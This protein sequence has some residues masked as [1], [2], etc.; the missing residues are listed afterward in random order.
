MSSRAVF[1]PKSIDRFRARRAGY[2]AFT[3]TCAG[4]GPSSAPASLYT[5]NEMRDPP[6]G[7]G[8]GDFGPYRRVWR[9]WADGHLSVD[10]LRHS[11]DIHDHPSR[12]P[13]SPEV[14]LPRVF[15]PPRWISCL[16]RTPSEL[17]CP[18]DAAR[19]R[20]EGWPLCGARR[21]A[22]HRRRE[23]H[24]RN[25]AR[26]TTE[27]QGRPYREDR[28]RWPLGILIRLVRSDRVAAGRR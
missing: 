22:W 13:P 8:A 20:D 2:R 14:A 26:W 9:T 24:R 12:S 18:R 28:L 3:G 15:R 7:P 25:G 1:G 6:N 23:G 19:G 10:Q 5:A 11:G 21:N 17:R 27:H 16:G 4:S